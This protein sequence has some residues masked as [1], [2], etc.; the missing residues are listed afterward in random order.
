MNGAD[1]ASVLIE[2]KSFIQK[3][4]KPFSQEVVKQA[5]K[6]DN[7]NFFNSSEDLKNYMESIFKKDCNLLL[8]S[9][10]NFGGIDLN[11]LASNL[12]KTKI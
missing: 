11:L 10:G 5:F 12:H 2:E 8:M 6:S 9:S 1:F 7:L 3:K 4:M